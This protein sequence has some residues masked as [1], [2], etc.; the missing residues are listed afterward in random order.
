MFSSKGMAKSCMCHGFWTH[1]S[2]SCHKCEITVAHNYVRIWA[3][4]SQNNLWLERVVSVS[5]DELHQISGSLLHW[6]LVLSLSFS[7]FCFLH[8]VCV[9]E[10]FLVGNWCYFCFIF[11]G[12]GNGAKMVV[13]VK[14][15]QQQI[16]SSLCCTHTHRHTTH[17]ENVRWSSTC[18]FCRK[19]HQFSKER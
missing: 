5:R 7:S 6:W 16:N 9:C 13:C 11:Y 3:S 12:S 10:R 15:L 4:I 18:F 19:N 8:F 1:T 17:T 14:K 2:N